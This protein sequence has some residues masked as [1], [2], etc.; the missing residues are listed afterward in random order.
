MKKLRYI[1]S[2]YN[3]GVIF[4]TNV[5]VN[6]EETQPFGI[7]VFQ[8]LGFDG[9]VHGLV[10]QTQSIQKPTVIG[11]ILCYFLIALITLFNGIVAL[12]I[13]L[14]TL[15]LKEML[16]KKWWK[17]YFKE[18]V[19]LNVLKPSTY[20]NYDFDMPPVILTEEEMK[21]FFSRKC[22][23]HIKKRFP[24]NPKMQDN[25]LLI[26]TSR[27]QYLGRLEGEWKAV[28]DYLQRRLSANEKTTQ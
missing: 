19:N 13:G 8:T 24:D 21:K 7:D 26:M 22:F 1:G 5:Y 28:D 2:Y 15:Q 9:E 4:K 16:T 14:V 20:T 18:L 3:N 6:N 10:W 27:L 12:F 17:E 23:T 25:Y 11:Y